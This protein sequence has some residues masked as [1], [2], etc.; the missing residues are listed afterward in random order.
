MERERQ[1]WTWYWSL[2]QSNPGTTGWD[3]VLLKKQ[4]WIHEKDISLAIDDGTPSGRR[5]KTSHDGRRIYVQTSKVEDRGGGWKER[6]PRAHVSE[7]QALKGVETRWMPIDG[8]GQLAS[9]ERSLAQTEATVTNRYYARHISH[10]SYLLVIK[11]C[12]ALP[13]NVTWLIVFTWLRNCKWSLYYDLLM[14]SWLTIVTSYDVM[15]LAHDSD[16]ES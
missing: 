3:R 12:W 8:L 14:V 13:Y 9:R 10:D 4:V 15:T 7:P 1:N 6:E 16:Y 5:P 11:V 2:T